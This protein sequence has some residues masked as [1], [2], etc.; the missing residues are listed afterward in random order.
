MNERK[1]H[2]VLFCLFVYLKRCHDLHIS[3]NADGPHRQY[4]NMDDFLNIFHHLFDPKC[5]NILLTVLQNNGQ[6]VDVTLDTG[7]DLC[8]KLG[9]SSSVY[10]DPF[11]ADSLPTH[12]HLH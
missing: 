4:Q 5:M 7:I 8:M 6:S 2:F 1:H 12:L 10:R 9:Y 3:F 11:Y